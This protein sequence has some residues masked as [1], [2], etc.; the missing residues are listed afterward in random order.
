VLDAATRLFIVIALLLSGVISGTKEPQPETVTTKTPAAPAKFAGTWE[1][2]F[3]TVVLRQEDAVVRGEYSMDDRPASIDGAVKDRRLAFSYAEHNARGEGW[4]ELAEDGATFEG[5]WRQHDSERWS[6]WTGKR[7][8]APSFDG[9]WKT[10]FGPMR[11]AL[12]NADCR[13]VY[14]RNGLHTISGTMGEKRL[15]FKYE[16]TDGERGEGW[17]ELAEDA[18]SFNGEWKSA[19]MTAPRRWDGTRVQPQKGVTWLVVLEAHWEGSLKDREFSYGEMQR[20]F[21]KR[22]PNVSFRHRFVHDLADVREFCGQLAFIPEP[23][24][25]YFSSHG[26]SD[27]I[28]VGNEVVTPEQIAGALT[29]VSNIKLLHFGACEV[30]NGDAPKRLLAAL[31]SGV[32]FPISGFA[33]TADWAGSAI[34]DFTY[35]DLILEY[36]LEPAAAVEEVRKSVRFADDTGKRGVIPSSLLRIYEAAPVQ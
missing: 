15:A 32:S 26:T 24:V 21:F 19:T 16:Q 20:A 6:A 4:F 13:G 14:E 12:K 22:L 23:V 35:L 34:I 30:M 31:P 18:Q 28:R 7:A 8:A 29:G 17:F 36:K 3:G 9:L 5:R 25:L 11:L 33:N 27:G 2:S 1:T 10:S